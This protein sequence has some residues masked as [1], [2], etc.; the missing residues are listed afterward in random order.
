[1]IEGLHN[2]LNVSVNPSTFAQAAIPQII[3]KTTEDFFGHM[4]KLL[5][6]AAE[7]CYNRIQKIDLLFCPAKPQG[8]M[9]VM[10]KLNTSGF[11]DIRDDIEFCVLLAREESV[12]VL[13][14]TP[15]GMKSWIRVTFSVPPDVLE[16]A[17]DR[18]E[19]FCRRH[20]KN[21]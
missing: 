7:I 16:E 8:S 11:E 20:A 13:P 3:E 12:I 19:S 9:F 1:V 2:I 15:L 21:V 18:I 5:S 17:F 4:L 10:V 14:G 6:R